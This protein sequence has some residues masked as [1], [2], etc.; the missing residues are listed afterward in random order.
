M[1]VAR[2]LVIIIIIIQKNKNVKSKKH[3]TGETTLQALASGKGYAAR[4]MSRN[5]LTCRG[6]GGRPDFPSFADDNN[7]DNDNK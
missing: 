4:G 3:R 2:I 5:R 7:D 6:V 1:Q